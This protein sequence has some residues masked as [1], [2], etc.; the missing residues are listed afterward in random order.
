MTRTSITETTTTYGYHCKVA[1]KRV[2]S[3]SPGLLRWYYEQRV[4]FCANG[5]RIQTTPRPTVRTN[6]YFGWGY[7]GANV[8]QYWYPAPTTYRV[9]SRGKFVLQM[10]WLTM[11]THRPEVTTTVR[12]SGRSTTSAKCGCN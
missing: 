1:T 11:N 10:G 5:K 8:E 12:A 9:H 6:A 2:E 3:H 7:R 4:P